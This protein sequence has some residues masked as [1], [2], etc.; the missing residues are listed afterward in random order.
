MSCRVLV[1]EDEIF[2]AIEIEGVVQDLGHL[3]I[4]IAADS[5]SALALAEH[6]EVAL[7]DL[8]LIDG[9]TG[10]DLGRMLA[11]KG[12]T[13]LFMTANPT[14]LGAG[15]PGTIGVMPKPATGADLKQAVEFVVARRLHD[16][17]V[18]PPRH[19]RLFEPSQAGP[20]LN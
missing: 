2:V 8:N 18:P 15:V 16:D 1:V 20:S 3:P 11:D 13:V 10:I 9:P 19:L 17:K 6:A 5:R 4:G 14:Q 12:V 7:V